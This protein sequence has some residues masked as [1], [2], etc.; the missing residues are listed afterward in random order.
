MMNMSAWHCYLISGKVM[1]NYTKGECT[2]DA[3]TV[4]EFTK[5]G[6]LMNWCKYFL[7][8]LLQACMDAHE[9]IGYFIYGYLLVSFSMWKWQS[10][11]GRNIS[12]S[13]DGPDH[14]TF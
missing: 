12:H 10:P 14:Q 6:A 4:A 8:K 3:I 1:K 9:N 2:L 11:K 13:E 7:T 5:N